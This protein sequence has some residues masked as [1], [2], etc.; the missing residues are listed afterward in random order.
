MKW[1]SGTLLHI[2]IAPR[3][4][5]EMLELDEAELVEGKGIINDRYYNQTGTYSSKPDIRDVT[6]IENEVL[7][8]LAVNQPPL[9]EKPIILFPVS[10]V[11]SRQVIS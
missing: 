10:F 3:A 6:L 11:T 7:K 8:A 2:H 5:V 1:N 9:Q 4:S